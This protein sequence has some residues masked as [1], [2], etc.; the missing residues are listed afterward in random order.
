MVLNGAN[1]PRNRRCPCDHLPSTRVR[2]PRLRLAANR[3]RPAEHRAHRLPRTSRRT[4]AA[5]AT[6]TRSP[7]TSTSSPRRAPGSPA[8]HPRPGLRPEPQRA[9]HRR[10]PDHAGQPSHAVEADEGAAAVHRLPPEG[11]LLRRRGGGWQ[12]RLQLRPAEGLGATPPRTGRRS[13]TCCRRTSRSSPSINF[14]V[15]HESQARAGEAA[16]QEE[17]RAA[18]A[19]GVRDRAKVK[20][21]PYYP[22]TPAVRECVGKYHDNVTAMDY[23]VGDVLKL[24]DDRKLADNTV[25][26]FFGDHGWGLSRGKRWPYDSG[27]AG[28]VPGPLAGQGQAGQRPRR[29][30]LLPRLRPDGAR[31]RR[32]RG[33][34]AHAGP[35]RSS[36]DKTQPAP[37]YVFAARDRMDETYDRIRSRPRRALPLRPQLPPGTAVLPVHQLH[38]RDADHEGLAAAGVRGEAEPGADAVL[39]ADQAEGRTLRPGE[40]PVRGQQPRRRGSAEIQGT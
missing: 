35:R 12:D 28:A 14:T 11:R 4:S 9:H 3:R 33:P 5:T 17:H 32:G 29:P 1:V 34:A 37:K 13:R 2:R 18:Q 8:L 20:L 26:I 22:D 7:R 30:G 25:V 36:G 27:T 23:L 19:R 40:G 24:L 31:A 6:R 39:A 21:P 10:V 15:T 16:V 38:G